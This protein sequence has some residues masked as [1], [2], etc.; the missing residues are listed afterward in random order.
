MA[1]PKPL[2]LPKSSPAARSFSTIQEDRREARLA[3]ANSPP[4]PETCSQDMFEMEAYSRRRS[5]SRSRQDTFQDTEPDTFQDTF[6]DT[7]PEIATQATE[8]DDSSSDESQQQI[9][10]LE[11][12]EG[13]LNR[14]NGSCMTARIGEPRRSPPLIAHNWVY[15]PASE[16][17]AK[18]KRS[19]TDQLNY[20]PSYANHALKNLPPHIKLRLPWACPEEIEFSELFEHCIRQIAI[21]KGGVPRRW[22]IGICASP[23]F[24]Y[25]LGHDAD[26]ECL[27][28]LVVAKTSEI[29]RPLEVDL[30][31]HYQDQ[32]DLLLQNITPYASGS[33]AGSPHLLYCGFT[34]MDASNALIR[35][36]RG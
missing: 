10:E 23:V 31:Q 1:C 14:S 2:F 9:P 34:D 7:E 29:T 19:P 13:D 11:E 21:I 22:Y 27:F 8:I 15:M 17:Q 36:R 25:N 33:T 18:K 20:W 16:R 28:L 26:Y 4:S 5:R 3:A 35:S 24:R 6:Q 32:H 12:E 30:V